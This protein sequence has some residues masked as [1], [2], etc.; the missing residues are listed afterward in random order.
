MTM[1]ALRRRGFT[2]IE[3]LVAMAVTLVVMG[4]VVGAVNSQQKSFYDGQMQRASQGSARA[5]VLY[6]EEKLRTAG[7]GVD[8]SL[9]FDF[10]TY[11]PSNYPG[12]PCPAENAPCPRE[13]QSNSDELVFYSRNP[14]YWVP[15]DP[16]A[17]PRGHAWRILSVAGNTVTVNARAGDSFAKGQVLSA[18]CRG[19]SYYAYMTV[20]QTIPALAADTNGLAVALDTVVAANPFRRQDLADQA[21]S[22]ATRASCFQTGLARLFQVD[23]YRFYV[24]PNYLGTSNGKG[25]YAPYLM[26]DMGIDLNLDGNVDLADQLAVAEGVE[27][28]QVAYVLANPALPVLGD[29]GAGGAAGVPYG[30]AAAAAGTFGTQVANVLITNGFPGAAPAQPDDSVY[31][32]TSAYGYSLGPPPDPQR[33]TNHQANIRQVK[34]AFVVR[35]PSPDRRGRTQIVLDGAFKLYN[36]V[37]APAWI[38]ASADPTPAADGYQRVQAET[39]VVVPNMTARGMTYF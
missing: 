33:L 24:Q 35:S 13:S 17:E 27:L 38:Q 5:A 25:Q 22:G 19:G 31:T 21:I 12:L 1:R 9:A 8:P 34:V 20:G 10:A 37:G 18:V 7:Y 16:T 2:L 4:F 15:A 26:L 14:M 28:M 11:T 39:R 32:P 30:V 6:V 23:R 3:L 36:L 29:A